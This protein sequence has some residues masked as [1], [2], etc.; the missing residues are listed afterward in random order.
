MT[1]RVLPQVGALEPI[2]ETSE[3]QVSRRGSREQ[4]RGDEDFSGPLRDRKC[5]DLSCLLAFL[6]LTLGLIAVAVFSKH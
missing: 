2:D 1:H 5:T 3:K 4:L 6:V